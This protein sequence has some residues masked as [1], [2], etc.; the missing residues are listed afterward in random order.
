MN[1]LAALVIIYGW[2]SHYR[3][4]LMEEVVL[5]RMR[6]GHLPLITPMVDGYIASA[7]CRDIG[8]IWALRPYGYSRWEYFLVADCADH[9]LTT[10]GLPDD[11]WMIQ[12]NILAEV[13]YPTA[14]RW[15]TIGS[16]VRVERRT[17]K[18]YR[19]FQLP[20]VSIYR[21]LLQ[22]ETVY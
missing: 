3:E 11:Q 7:D 8:Q 2:A 14:K 9:T 19:P 18:V 21:R 5:N 6:T 10:G 12:N 22:D 16:W 20:S 15:D 4:G 17:H 1:A 13:N